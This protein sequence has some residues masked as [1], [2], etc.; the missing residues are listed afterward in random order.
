MKKFILNKRAEKSYHKK[1]KQDHIKVSKSNRST[2]HKYPINMNKQF[3]NKLLVER[4]V[5]RNA[6]FVDGFCENYFCDTKLASSIITCCHFAMSTK[7][8]V[9]T[10]GRSKRK[11]F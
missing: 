9:N 8:S 3:F 11:V 1:D 10:A 5:A 2:V 6:F 7:D 4:K